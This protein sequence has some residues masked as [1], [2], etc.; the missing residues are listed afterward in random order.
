M[1]LQEAR[2]LLMV[3]VDLAYSFTGGK[4][5]CELRGKCLKKIMHKTK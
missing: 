5:M 3:K 1:N 4:E 2:Y